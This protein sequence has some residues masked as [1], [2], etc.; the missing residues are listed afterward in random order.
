M[1]TMADSQEER[2]DTLGDSPEAEVSDSS[3][4][5]AV[6]IVS[7]LPAGLCN[8]GDELAAFASEGYDAATAHDDWTDDDSIDI[9]E[10]EEDMAEF[11][12]AMEQEGDWDEGMPGPG[13]EPHYVGGTPHYPCRNPT[14]LPA[15][16]QP[17]MQ[18]EK[19]AVLTI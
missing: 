17:C 5:Q 15:S 8:P 4:A 18:V 14:V 12:G 7:N 9:D 19:K 2:S 16:A 6:R 11:E 13:Y 3:A 1:K 10:L